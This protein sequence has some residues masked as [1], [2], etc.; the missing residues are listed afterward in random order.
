MIAVAGLFDCELDVLPGV[1]RLF[2]SFEQ[3]DERLLKPLV[4]VRDL[5]GRRI[6][7][8]VHGNWRPD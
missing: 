1:V 7:D 8:S 6:R 5:L 3:L 2:V 4:Q